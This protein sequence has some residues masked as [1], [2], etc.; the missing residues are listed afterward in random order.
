MDRRIANWTSLVLF[1][2]LAACRTTDGSQDQQKDTP[3]PDTAQPQ[4]TPP[5]T[6]PTRAAGNDHPSFTIPDEP[7]LPNRPANAPKFIQAPDTGDVPALVHLAAI[8]AKGGELVVYVGATWCEPCQRFH[9]A[10]EHGDLDAK[11]AGWTFLQFDADRDHDRLV[12]AGYHSHYIP[13]FVVPGPDGHASTKMI[14][15][16]I[17]GPGSPDQITPRLLAMV[18]GS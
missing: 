15:G 12:A 6:L 5:P 3:A 18:N 16:S 14:E 2:M 11:L 9:H 1:S 10:V 17:T 7:P 13:L 8:K 4:K